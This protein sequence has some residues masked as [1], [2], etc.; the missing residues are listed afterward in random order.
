MS[1]TLMKITVYKVKDSQGNILR[2][3]ETYKQAYTYKIM[4][5]RHDWTIE[6]F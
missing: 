2:V 1:L 6:S 3:F 5:N 4:C